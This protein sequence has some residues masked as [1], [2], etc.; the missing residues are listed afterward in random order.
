MRGSIEGLEVKDAEP[1]FDPMPLAMKDVKLDSDEEPRP[2]IDVVDFELSIE[3]RRLMQQLD[4][5]T[6]V[7]W[8]TRDRLVYYDSAQKVVSALPNARLIT[9]SGAGHLP[10]EER[11][12][13]F[14]SALIPFIRAEY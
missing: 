2:E 14:N 11:P 10:Y 13:E 1:I 5:P 7:I 8:G 4:V 12:E 3:V 6:L 9:I